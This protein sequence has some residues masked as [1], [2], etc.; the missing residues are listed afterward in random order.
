MELT[1][2]VEVGENGLGYRFAVGSIPD[3]GGGVRWIGFADSDEGAFIFS[4]ISEGH[5][6]GITDRD[7]AIRLTGAIAQSPEHGYGGVE[8][9]F[10]EEPLRGRPED[11][12]CENC[13]SIGCG[14][15][16]EYDAPDYY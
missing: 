10:V 12:T 13:R 16:C 1:E 9:W 14:G 2:R 7:R 4:Q 5:V 11:F 6:V 3:E 15:D 8:T